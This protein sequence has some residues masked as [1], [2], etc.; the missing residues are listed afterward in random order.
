MTFTTP[1]FE[2]ND[3]AAYNKAL[4][5]DMGELYDDPLGFVLYAYRWGK[6]DLEHYDG[7]D[8]W[9]RG[10]LS[11]WGQEIRARNFDGYTPVLPQLMSTVSGHG[12]GKSALT[13]WAVDFIM[14]TRPFCKGTVTANTSPQLNTK[15]WAEIAKWTKRCLTG[16]WFKVTSGQG[17]MKMQHRK[18]PETWRC[19]GI[20]WREGVPEAFAG[21]HAPNSTSFYLFDEASAIPKL[22][23]ETAMGGLATGEPMIMLFSNGTQTSGYFYETHRDEKVAKH[24]KRYNVDARDAKM[25]N[26]RLHEQW[27]EEYGIDSDFV[28]VRILGDFP[29]Q[30]SQQFI[31]TDLVE[32]ARKAEVVA[33]PV[34]PLI[35][36][37]DVARYGDDKSVM[38][39]RRGR[40]ARSIP[41]QK[42][43]GYDAVELSYMIAEAARTRLPDAIIVDGGG[44]GGPVV[45]ILRH[46]KIANVHE[47]NFGGKSP[48]ADYANMA[49]YMMKKLRD[50]LREG[51]AI[52]DSPELQTELISREYF[53]NLNNQIMLEPKE[54]QKMR[55]GRSPDDADA[56]CLTYAKHIGARTIEDTAQE[57][58]GGF[59][60]AMAG[61]YNPFA[62][63]NR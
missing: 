14:S 32:N 9:Q 59:N 10:F 54:A 4:S 34:E 62:R 40:D 36:G 43:Q 49:T 53:F 57:L 11:E 58:A 41:P 61:D 3:A 15:T 39:F 45:D 28:K 24:W 44:N 56:L 33:S 27:I 19:D 20:A 42:L 8:S 17:A 26:H 18:H 23:L 6:G 60:P 1:L 7:P 16:H 29:N 63:N 12:V 13:A 50:G 2:G 30:S 47:V 31:P 21:Q 5:R 38:R 55:I 22:I 52:D 46:M 35:L 48:D 25:A 51:L 37:V